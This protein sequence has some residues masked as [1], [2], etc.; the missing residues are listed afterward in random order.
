MPVER[1]PLSGDTMASGTSRLKDL[2]LA[3]VE[4]PDP[5]E[6]AALLDRECPGDTALRAG[7]EAVL[8]AY[9]GA[10]GF[11][12]SD[13][14]RTAAAPT[15]GPADSTGN[16]EPGTIDAADPTTGQYRLG[17]EQGTYATGPW[18]QQGGAT[19]TGVVIAGRY[20]L[21]EVLG[22]GGMGT[23]YRASQTEPV[24][25]QV[26]LKLIKGGADSRAVLARFEAERQALALMDHPNIARVYD[27]GVTPPAYPGG[28]PCP[29]F[30]MELV[31]GVPLTAY[32][33]R[34]RHPL[35]ARLELFVS[36]CQAVQHAH[37][38]GI[39]HRDLKPG[40][41]LVAEVDGR[42]APKV[43]DFGVAKATEQSLTDLSLGDTGA[44]VGT[45]AYMSPEQADPA[46]ADIDTRTDVYALGVVL[47]ELLVGSPPIDAKQFKR[48][49]VLEM[50]RLVR[51]VTPPRP[52][53]KLSTAADL[54]TVAANRGTEPTSLTKVLRGE[55]DWVVMK[56]LEKD[57]SRR[58]ESASGLARDLERY[59]ADEVVEARPPSA[60]YRVRKFVRR[61]RLEVAAAAVVVL[62]LVGGVIGTTLGMIEARRQKAAADENWGRA[63][64]ERG[65][66][67]E[68]F[69]TA[70]DQ[71]LNMGTY[72]TQF[73]TGQK[74]HRIADQARR[75]ALDTARKQFDE[76]RASRPDDAILQTQAAALHRYTANVSRTL[77]DYPAA[78]AAYAASIRIQEGLADRFP[79]EPK[80]RLTL[81]LT[82]GDR[83]LLEKRM[84]KLTEAAATLDRALALA[85]PPGA[86]EDDSYNRAVGWL[87]HDRAML[88]YL[89]GR[90][91]D[92]ARSADRAVDRL[93]R[94]KARTTET[95]YAIDPLL[96]VM[97]VNDL[98]I[99]RR[100]LG[101]TAEA[102]AAHDE[103][104]A[105]MT[106]VAGSKPGRDE[107]YWANEVRRE[108]A[109]TVAAIPAHQ[110][111]EAAALAEIARAAE[112]LVD[113]YASVAHYREK[114][115]AIYLQ[116]GE[117]LTMLGQLDPAAAELAKSL[118][119]S[120]ELIDRFGAQSAFL[121]VRGQTFLAIGRVKAA[122]GK[123]DEA[124]AN[125]KNA[126]KVF[127]L[128]L[129]FDSD[130]AHH[131]RGLA[132][133]E[134]AL[135]EK[136]K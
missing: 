60:G 5:A 38:K 11:A 121:L 7:V 64:T 17:V 114:L 58:Y 86:A 43:I 79:D 45:P 63:E 55:L 136:G 39:I 131:R 123:A 41:I 133:A 94:I 47:Y 56:A 59:L 98:A 113:E 20:T 69:A 75:D 135:T 105:R 127:E 40:N 82:L 119:V 33:D 104:V 76:F 28:L 61:H 6:R 93:D 50:L 66:A 48:G 29:F 42:P 8:A 100:E 78:A 27:G 103:A 85:D 97:A 92:S 68:N 109:K 1:P 112:K 122:A 13:T 89:R 115:A 72:I 134:R 21:G 22:E 2:F 125:W 31:N 84:G 107:L 73:E 4:R 65:R 57:R 117:L 9:A 53:T 44:I 102:L 16:Y 70:R 108:R 120:R 81:A 32:C 130:N 12:D 30:V 128:A 129:K 90:F 37:Q 74:D 10:G 99:A 23:V 15:D 67:E 34:N 14:S 101:R 51:D 18:N 80:P 116:R 36:V 88:A 110:A 83:A 118:A 87:E 49:G 24:K 91:E 106:K 124:V 3:A 54:P 71:I 77:S 26:A 46:S 35:R 62:A 111:A 95:R 96:A 52:S 19:A 132:A 25:R 126:A